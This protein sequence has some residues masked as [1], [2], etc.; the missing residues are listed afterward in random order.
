MSTAR[1]AWPILCLAA[2]PAGCL[3]Q[4][5]AANPP[6]TT[7]A[8]PPAAPTPPAAPA[9]RADDRLIIS[10][11]GATLTDT[12]GGGGGSI[13]YLHQSSADLSFGAAAEHQRLAGAYWTFGSLS[14]AFTHR[15]T[16]SVRWSVHGEVHEGAGHTGEHSFDYGIEALGVS[17]TTHGMTADLE[18]RQIDV[19]TNHGSLPKLTLSKAWGN[20]WLTTVAYAYSFGGNLNTEYSLVR[21]DFY[22]PGY[23]LLAGGTFGRVNPAVINVNGLLLSEAKHLAEVFAGVTKPLHRIDLSLLADEIDLP[24]SK[25]FTVT[26]TATLHLH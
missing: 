10:A 18:D 17:A 8:A 9:W 24:G 13:A 12:G 15:L 16:D 11:D 7:A 3:A 26:L 25:R 1:I 20:S 19:D 14:G 21:V 4:E 23:S 22:Q 6:S 2:I 5:S